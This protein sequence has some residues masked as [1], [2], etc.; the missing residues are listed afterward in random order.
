MERK[1]DCIC[2]KERKYYTEDIIERAIDELQDRL[3]EEEIKIDETYVIEIDDVINEIADN[4]IPIYTY[5]LLQYASTNFDLIQPSDLQGDNPS[6]I[7]II[8]ANIYEIL[9]EELYAYVST[10]QDKDN[11]TEELLESFKPKKRSK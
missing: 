8:Q 9:T 1:K 11:E 5:D 4:N 3:K 7:S 6:V 10:I 2:S